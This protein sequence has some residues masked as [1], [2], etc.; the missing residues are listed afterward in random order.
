MDEDV[1]FQL[2]VFKTVIETGSITAAAAAL[3]MSNSAVSR[4]VQA[5]EAIF[6]ETLLER[7]SGHSATATTAG[8]HAYKYASL[9][10]ELNKLLGGGGE[11]N[12]QALLQ[13]AV[14]SIGA[15]PFIA[16]K[17]LPP[18]IKEFIS[19]RP[20]TEIDLRTGRTSEIVKLVRDNEVDLGFVLVAMDEKIDGLNA[21]SVGQER[22]GIFAVPTHPLANRVDVS[23]AE[24]SEYS[25]VTPGGGN[26]VDDK[27]I[28][29][30]LSRM[31]PGSIRSAG[32][33]PA[34]TIWYGLSG[35]SPNLCLAICG[36]V[37]A[38]LA[39]GELVEIDIDAAP[40]FYDVQMIW[41][42]EWSLPTASHAFLAF[43]RSQHD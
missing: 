39:S 43:A 12:L 13:S 3:S 30:L 4:H 38:E 11:A 1:D 7:T 22:L 29:L 8:D 37:E 14:C 10:D 31:G 16:E 28:L 25:F 23:C 41:R 20:K 27:R 36:R 40:I 18:V 35:D 42:D 6:K 32:E 17:H 21:E 19:Q 15:H 9:L 26:R 24:V 34:G 5:V 2:S 33:P